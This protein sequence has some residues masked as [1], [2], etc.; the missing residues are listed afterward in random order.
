[1]KR[2]LACIAFLGIF[3]SIAVAHPGVGIVIDTKGNIF[4]TDL[5]HVWKITPDGS[6][7]IAVRDVHTHELYIDSEDNLYGEHEWYE[8]EATDKWGNYVWR[9][10]SEGVFEKTIDDVEGFLDNNTLVRDL[11]GN[12]YWAIKMNGYEQVMRHNPDGSD[13]LATDHHFD[14]IRW[15][16]YSKHDSHLYIVD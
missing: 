1:M 15:M 13:I 16:Y 4:Y 9:L 3:V 12:S 2:I 11:Q 10:S 8:G 6:H 7:E 5:T 14:D